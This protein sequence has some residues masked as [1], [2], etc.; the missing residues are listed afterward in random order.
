MSV[1][2]RE[3][4]RTDCEPV[5]EFPAVPIKRNCRL[6]IVLMV[7]VG[8]LLTS[9]HAIAVQKQFAAPS[10]SGGMGWI[11]T[12]QPLS[13]RALRGKVVLLDFWTYCCINC[14]HILPT[15]KQL[16][17]KYPN[18]LVVI[19][20][21]S[22]K[23]RTERDL[24]N[25]RRAVLRYEISHPVLN[26]GRQAVWRRWNV[27][28]WPTLF[29]VDP[30]G[31]VWSWQ[32]GETPFE[33]IDRDI[34]RIIQIHRNKGT[35][36]EQPIRF[37]LDRSRLKPT[38]LL[39]PGKVIVDA[40][41]ERVYIADS[42]HH[43]IVIAGFDGKLLDTIGSG[44]AGQIDG[45]FST[46]SFRDP[47]GMVLSGNTLYIAD[48]LNHLVRAADVSTGQVTTL[49]G[50]GR[51]LP[52][53]ETLTRYST[54]PRQYALSNPWDLALIGS[55]LFIAMAGTHQ[56]A[57]L[58]LAGSGIGVFSGTGVE[59]IQ[60]GQRTMA[61]HA[62]P[63]GLATDGRNLFVVDSEGSSLRAVS[64]PP[65]NRVTTLVGTSGLPQFKSL[66]AFGDRDGR[67]SR[68]RLQHP[69]GVA[70]HANSIYIADTYNHKIKLVNPITRTCST[71]AGDRSA[72]PGISP[73]QLH[74]P[75]GL[76]VHGQT[77]YIADTNNNRV[78]TVDLHTQESRLFEIEGLAPPA[79]A[80]GQ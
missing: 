73:L 70:F 30:E 46:S 28:R 18:E 33:A 32:S 3:S 67:G 41:N 62:Q 65:Q 68:V 49:A 50:T 76:A 60:D 64:L 15:L 8:L 66:F 25:I 72:G 31:M 9:R 47:Q 36:N 1:V 24:E 48:N 20:V 17:E 69:I 79:A 13:M 35:L 23:F 11:N 27:N 5:W 40:D 59:D 78:V 22:A 51:M 80:R 43:R 75:A 4:H 61:A 21:H 29:L 52:S 53:Y 2:C 7:M 63:S 44:L 54:T 34:A 6:A 71:L 14:M 12:S 58:D 10:L 56:I 77:L 37:E 57:V 45:D 16:E 74:E 42:G 26:D 19:G 38:P 39:F 55:K